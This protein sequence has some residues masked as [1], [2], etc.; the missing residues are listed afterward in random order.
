[1]ML[2]NL[3]IN[4]VFLLLG[5]FSLQ[6][7]TADALSFPLLA[8]EV[9]VEESIVD[10]DDLNLSYETTQTDS[11]AGGSATITSQPRFEN[12]S[13][14]SNSPKRNYTSRELHNKAPLFIL[15]CCLKVDC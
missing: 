10:I 8:T 13:S 5:F 14:I 7:V 4:L 12:N 15:Y 3:N 11:D 1:M 2:K 9:E 6:S